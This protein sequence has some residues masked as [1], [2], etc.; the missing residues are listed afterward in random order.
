MTLA[1]SCAA[2]EATHRFV[3]IGGE[4]TPYSLAGVAVAIE[5]GFIARAVGCLEPGGP[6]HGSSDRAQVFRDRIAA[7]PVGEVW[8]R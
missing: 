7:Q 4:M 5:R 8:R 2:T 3:W 6:G 1:R